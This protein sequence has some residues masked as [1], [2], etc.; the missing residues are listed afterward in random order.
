[1][2]NTE[3]IQL[4]EVVKKFGRNIVLDGVNLSIPENQITGII[5]ASGEGK[6]TILKLIVGFYKPTKGEITYLRRSIYNDLTHVSKT[7]GFATDDGS[8]YG[9][10]TVKE[11]LH[12]FGYLY[13]MKRKEVWTRGKELLDFV[14]LSEAE[15]T[16]ARNLSVG[17]KKRLDFACSMMHSPAVLIMDE[18]TADL[19]PLLRKQILSM[20]RI[21]RDK[22]TTIVLTTQLLEEMDSLCDKIAIL[23]DK[24]IVEEGEPSA[25]RAKYRVNN[26]NDVFEK[27]FSR[28]INNLKT[29]KKARKPRAEKKQ[30]K[31]EE[32]IPETAD[33][34]TN[35]V[36]N[37]ENIEEE[38]KE[39]TTDLSGGENE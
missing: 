29:E 25:I 20:I 38:K 33:T 23:H 17:M 8:F 28:Q 31:P 27:I 18:P 10:L 26:L 36:E 9:N 24:K 16:R 19:D 37:V 6:S 39:L 15:N 5:G 34:T 21:L 14:G 4:K 2:M 11:N 12:H 13:N 30:D 35:I 22:G 1:M 3:L 7:F 32:V